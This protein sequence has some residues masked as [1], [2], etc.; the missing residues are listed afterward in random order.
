MSTKDVR[1]DTK[2]TS[3]F[4]AAVCETFPS[5]SAF[6][7]RASATRMRMPSRKCSRWCCTC[8]SRVSRA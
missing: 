7:C 4:G 1:V 5:E 3:S 8:Q 2:L 6:A